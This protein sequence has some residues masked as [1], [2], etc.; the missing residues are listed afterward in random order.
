MTKELLISIIL[1]SVSK[2]KGVEVSRVAIQTSAI[3]L[4]LIAIVVDRTSNSMPPN[5]FLRLHLI[6]EAQDLHAVVV[7]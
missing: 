3:S 4:V 5:F 2:C 6:A 1:E 7:K